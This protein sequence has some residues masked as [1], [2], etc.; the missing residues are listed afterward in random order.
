MPPQSDSVSG[1]LIAFMEH[2]DQWELLQ[3]EPALIDAAVEEILRYT[4]P[5][6][7]FRRTATVDVELGGQKIEAGEKV[8]LWYPSGNRSMSWTTGSTVFTI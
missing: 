8:T 1:G 6:N 5:V 3:R 2:A 4:S 7:F